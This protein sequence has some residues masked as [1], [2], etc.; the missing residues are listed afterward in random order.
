MILSNINNMNMFLLE[1]IEGFLA[2]IVQLEN[3]NIFIEMLKKQMFLLK[4]VWHYH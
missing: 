2:S 3:L 4:N 1:L